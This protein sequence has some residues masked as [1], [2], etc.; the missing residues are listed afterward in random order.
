MNSLVE[1]G[2]LAGRALARL[3]NC[4]GL[5]GLGGNRLELALVRLMNQ[6]KD[7]F[8]TDAEIC[9]LLEDQGAGLVLGLS[10][11]TLLAISSLSFI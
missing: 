7:F 2:C 6:D 9:V 5:S 8:L 10:S 11:A 1:A 4:R 3:E